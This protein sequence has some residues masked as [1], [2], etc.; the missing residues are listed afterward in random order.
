MNICLAHCPALGWS[1]HM[2]W[3][4]LADFYQQRLVNK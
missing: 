4:Q 3:D 1:T 2:A